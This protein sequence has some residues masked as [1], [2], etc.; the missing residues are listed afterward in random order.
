MYVQG[1]KNWKSYNLVKLVLTIP[2]TSV[3]TKW[4]FFALKRTKCYLHKAQGQE[5]LSFLSLPVIGNR[6]LATSKSK[7]TFF[8]D[9][10]DIFVTKPK[11]DCNTV[12]NKTYGLEL[13]LK[14]SVDILHVK[15]SSAFLCVSL[16][17]TREVDDCIYVSPIRPVTLRYC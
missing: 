6:F 11:K 1:N 9:G 3:S 7:L 8:D 14:P 2:A 17:N 10:I 4:S 16:Q 12:H 15:F 5:R 13:Q